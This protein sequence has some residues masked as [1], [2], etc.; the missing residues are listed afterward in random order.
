MKWSS[1]L[2][3]LHD[4][5]GKLGTMGVTSRTEI[6]SAIYKKGHKRYIH[7]SIY[8][9]I[10]IYSVYVLFIYIYDFFNCYLAEPQPTFSHYWGDSLTHPMLITCVLHIQPEGHRKSR[11]QVG[12]RSPAERGRANL[13]ILIT[14]S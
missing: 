3:D 5:W 2:L 7:I 9:Y 13:S 8:I 10:Y 1:S 12:S 4:S 11:N 6:I 14:T